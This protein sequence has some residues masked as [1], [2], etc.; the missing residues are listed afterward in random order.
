MG[1]SHDLPEKRFWRFVS[2]ASECWEWQGG[3]D[4]RGYGRFFNG[5]HNV[6][7]HRFSFALHAKTEPGDLN[8][9]HHCD[10]PGCVNPDHL[11]LGTHTE[12]MADMRRKGRQRPLST[13]AR[14]SRIGS[15]VIDEATAKI[16]AERLALA[17]RSASGRIRRGAI[18]SIA[19]ELNV[20]C[21]IISH[22][23]SGSWAHATQE[24]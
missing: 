16:I 1:A 8:V 11:F 20:S 14:G 15:S 7:A 13:H 3:R 4:H 18:K 6:A 22:I 12:N 19:A 10:N 24:I 23:R 2:K 21:H 9:C 17:P 5:Q